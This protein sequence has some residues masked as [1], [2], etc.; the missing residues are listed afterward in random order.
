MNDMPTLDNHSPRGDGQN[1]FRFVLDVLSRH[2]KQIVFCTAL[3]AGVGAVVGLAL[4]DGR[5]EYTAVATL[6]VKPSLYDTAWMQDLGVEFSGPMTAKSVATQISSRALAE[7]VVRALIQDDM[8]Q[9]AS[10]GGIASDDEMSARAEALEGALLLESRD[11]A[12]MLLVNARANTEQDAR[13]QAD[14]AARVLIEHSREWFEDEQYAFRESLRQDLARLRQ[15]LDEAETARWAFQEEMGFRT[16]ADVWADLE[17]KNEEQRELENRRDAIE[18]QLAELEDE[19]AAN[20]AQLPD[21]LGSVSSATVEQLKDELDELLGEKAEMLVDWLPGSPAIDAIDQDVDAKR[22]AILIAIED[23][24]AGDAAGGGWEKQK[25]LQ[26][27]QARLEFE[28]DDLAI[29]FATLS[30]LVAGLEEQLPALA[31]RRLEYEQLVHQ[32]EQIRNQF[33]FL[34]Q[35]DFEMQAAQSRR[36]ASLERRDAV[37]I[38]PY[39]SGTPSP[40]WV[41]VVMGAAIG[42]LIGFAFAMMREMTDTSIRSSED[43]NQHLGLEVLG[44]IPLMRLPRRKHAKG[45]QDGG[46]LDPHVI[47]HFDPKSPISEAYRALRTNFQFATLQK[48]PKTIMVTSAVP[49]EGK[50]V[51]AVNFAVT[52]ADRGLR[53]LLLDTDLRRPNVHRVLRMER[54]LGLADVLR[55][56]ANI[57]QTVRQ[58]AVPNLFAVSSGKVPA[59]PSELIAGDAMAQLIADLQT[60]FDLIV[61]D[62][63]S[64]HVVTDPVLLATHVDAVLLVVA[65]NNARRETIRRAL[66]F[67]QTAK[68]AIA[69]VVLNGLEASRRHY[70]YYYYYNADSPGHQRR[71]WYRPLAG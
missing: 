28:L 67:L 34:L 18:A 68:P 12:G 40:V 11:E 38:L 41:T 10:W 70:Y 52:M 59:N 66:R 6:V 16:H 49:A 46:A 27:Q 7:D 57:D 26:A 65:A 63:P 33:A 35:K 32:T 24:G 39:F 31:E 14:Y 3:V 25:Q 22:M 37:A 53:V 1:Q 5:Y 13:R 60:K 48:Q 71:R 36:A 20:R 69:G 61:C 15:E 2:W 44:T 19:L 55:G 50:T 43:V 4:E 21:T 8:A 47:T 30:Q 58:T 29:R 23:L 51:T 45:G 56:A 54:G 42:F 9:G 64:V 17:K 62:A